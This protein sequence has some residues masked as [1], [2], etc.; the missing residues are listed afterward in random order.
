MK[1]IITAAILCAFLLSAFLGCDRTEDSA[2]DNKNNDVETPNIISEEQNEA[3]ASSLPNTDEIFQNAEALE[4]YKTA[5]ELLEAGDLYGA[6]DIFLEIKDFRDVQGYLSRFN[7]KYEGCT[8]FSENNNHITILRYDEFG[9]NIY[10]E[11]FYPDI[12][13]S[14]RYFYQYDENERLSG[15]G[16][17]NEDGEKIHIELYGYDEQGRPNS[18]KGSAGSY[19]YCTLEYDENGN[20]S[21]V[22]YGGGST[23]ENF[24]DADGNLSE[25]T[26]RSDGDVL[27]RSVYQYNE[28]GDVVRI[29]TS[30][31]AGLIR[32]IYYQ[33]EYDEAGRITKRASSFGDAQSFYE[34]GYDEF[35]YDE[36]GNTVKHGRY[37]SPTDFLIFYSV[38]DE[39]GK[40]VE[41]IREDETGVTSYWLYEYDEYGNLVREIEKK[42]KDSK[43]VESMV[44]YTG[45]RLYY[46]PY[47]LIEMPPELVGKG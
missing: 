7:F 30:D 40:L 28:Q 12:S 32:D 41:R 10:S 9:K 23:K 16:Y 33:Y 21:K 43:T 20:I 46:N 24:Y 29:T 37:D 31:Q 17:L 36:F 47:P 45:Y 1:K 27:L 5:L 25:E 35:E 42:N 11:L 34:E 44:V 14:Y 6:Y 38:Y 3:D 39:N 19:S 2:K 26:L 4:K 13:R 18:V 8:C 22:Y 15:R